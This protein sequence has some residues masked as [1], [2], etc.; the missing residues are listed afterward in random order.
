[1]RVGVDFAKS[2]VLIIPTRFGDQA[3]SKACLRYERLYN[4]YYYCSRLDHEDKDYV[5]KSV[6]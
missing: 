3:K 5:K 2:L 1:M 4:F 6:D